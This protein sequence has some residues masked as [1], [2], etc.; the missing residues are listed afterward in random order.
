MRY[1]LNCQLAWQVGPLPSK[2]PALISRLHTLCGDM[3]SLD[4]AQ[5]NVINQNVQ[6]SNLRIE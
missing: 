6:K 1:M 5:K 4:S 3:V 2:T